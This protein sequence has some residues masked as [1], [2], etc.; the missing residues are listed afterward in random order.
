[1]FACPYGARYYDEKSLKVEKCNLC[2]SRVAKGLLPACV[3]TC[4]VKARDF[5]EGGLPEGALRLSG[6]TFH[7][8]SVEGLEGASRLTYILPERWKQNER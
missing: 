4:P 5:D 6:G 7:L 3:A 1:M 2:L 8:S